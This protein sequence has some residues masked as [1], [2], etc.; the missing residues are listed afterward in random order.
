MLATNWRSNFDRYINIQSASQV[1]VQRADGETFLS[2]L[3]GSVWSTDTD[4]DYTFTASGT[5]GR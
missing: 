1:S 5:T 2:T 3:S 4:V